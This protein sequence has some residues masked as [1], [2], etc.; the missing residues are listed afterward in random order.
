MLLLFFDFFSHFFSSL[1]LDFF[2]V[3]GRIGNF[4]CFWGSS[5]NI[6]IKNYHKND[7]N[8]EIFF[9]FEIKIKIKDDGMMKVSNFLQKVMKVF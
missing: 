9:C 4:F 7:A 2:F 3:L 5:N 6:E 1:K 8:P